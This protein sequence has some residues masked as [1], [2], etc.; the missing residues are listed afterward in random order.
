MHFTIH[1][2]TIQG[3]LNRLPQEQ[4]RSA[5]EVHVRALNIYQIT[6]WHTFENSD[7]ERVL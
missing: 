7:K 1:E 6:D 3:Y 2:S 5:A 4:N